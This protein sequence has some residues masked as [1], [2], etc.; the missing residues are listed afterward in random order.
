MSELP[1]EYRRF[2]LNTRGFRLQ[3]EGLSHSASAP[4][5]TSIISRVIA[6]WRTLFNARGAPPPRAAARL[7][8]LARR[9]RRRYSLLQRFSARDD[10]DDFSGDRRLAHFIHVQRQLIDHLRRVARRRVHRRHLRGEERGV[11]FEQ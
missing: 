8:S 5:T 11:R 3:A 1:V 7:A 10:L 2:R 9:S 6:A 4:E